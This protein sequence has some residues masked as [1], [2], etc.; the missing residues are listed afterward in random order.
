MGDRETLISMGFAQD[1]VEWALRDTPPG[2]DLQTLMDHIFEHEAQAVP[3]PQASQTYG[4]PSHPPPPH[5]QVQAPPL[6]P[7]SPSP[8]PLAQSMASMSINQVTPDPVQP[9][10][11]FESDAVQRYA[12]FLEDH[13]EHLKEAR[14]DLISA[15]ALH[16]VITRFLKEE[17]ERWRNEFGLPAPAPEESTSTT[18]SSQDA[19]QGNREETLKVEE[20]GPVITVENTEEQEEQKPKS[21]V[22]DPIAVYDPTRPRIPPLESGQEF[23]DRVITGYDADEPVENA[24]KRAWEIHPRMSEEVSNLRWSS[25]IFDATPYDDSF[26]RRAEAHSARLS[27]LHL[28]GDWDTANRLEE[29]YSERERV[30]RQQKNRS[31]FED[32]C[33]KYLNPAREMVH[34]AFADIHPIYA[35]L[36]GYLEEDNPELDVVRAIAAL[37]QVSETMETGMRT[38]AELE[39]DHMRRE[40]ELQREVITDDKSRSDP[41]GDASKFEKQH[42]LRLLE[43]KAQRTAQR[44]DRRAPFFALSTRRIKEAIAGVD[45]DQE[46]LQQHLRTLLDTVPPTIPLDQEEARA[47][48]GDTAPSKVPLPSIELHAQITSAQSS[49]WSVHAMTNDMRSVLRGLERKQMWEKREDDLAQ[50]AASETRAGRGDNWYFGPGSAMRDRGEKEDEETERLFDKENDR[51]REE[52]NAFMAPVRDYMTSY[53][54]R[55]ML[56]LQKL[57]MGMTAHGPMKSSVNIPSGS[58]GDSTAAL[59]AMQKMMMQQQQTQMISNMMWSQHAA[60]MSVINNIGSSNSSW[61][62]KYY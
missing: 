46:L 50:L 25:G 6:P 5:L 36:Q 33:R 58:G 42:E 49:L 13:K 48:E 27:E 21:D 59:S 34:K 40:F 28:R 11:S 16:A 56:V 62:V 37:E 39:D 15:I 9:T 32:Y 24:K 26:N 23:L 14:T 44:A 41:W 19:S 29:E 52:F 31:D 18:R 43:L 45:R 7:R 47:K 35:E 8:A 55:E 30:I 51:R 53:K 4:P 22:Y 57:T 10:S 2:A 20:P 1:R 3:P 60:R 12:A 38:L 61:V 54:D 17:G